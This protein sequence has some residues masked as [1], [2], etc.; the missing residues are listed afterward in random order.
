MGEVY[1]IYIIRIKEILQHI[2]QNFMQDNKIQK[3]IKQI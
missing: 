3:K 2:I 1:I